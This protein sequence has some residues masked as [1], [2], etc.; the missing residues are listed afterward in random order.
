MKRDRIEKIARNIMIISAVAVIIADLFFAYFIDRHNA[1]GLLNFGYGVNLSF[2]LMFSCPI[3][4]VLINS[5]T[6]IKEMLLMRAKLHTKAKTKL[7]VISFILAVVGFSLYFIAS[8]IT[9]QFAIV[10]GAISVI[11]IL[12]SIIVFFV[13]IKNV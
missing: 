7:S 3:I 13:Y 12:L 5:V 1:S 10:L 6:F 9:S 8:S 2:L 11:L 4:F